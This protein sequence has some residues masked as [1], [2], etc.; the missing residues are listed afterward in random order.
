MSKPAILHICLSQGWGGLEMYP[1]RTSE[2]LADRGYTVFGLCIAGTPVAESMR[3]AGVEVFEVLSKNSLI[4]SQLFELNRWLVQRNVSIVHC[5]KSGDILISALLNLLLRRKTLFTEHMGVK[6]PKKD[7]YHRL[8]YAHIDQVLAISD[9][10]YERNIKSLPVPEGKI[11]R[12]WL[13]T[14]IQLDPVEDPQKIKRIKDEIALP[15]QSIVVGNIGRICSGKG[16]MELLETFNLLTEQYP[17]LHLL[18]VGGLEVSEGADVNFVQKLKS[19]IH[20]LR[21]N[22]RVHLIGFRKDTCQMLSIMDIVC[23]PNHN[24]AFGLTAI[25]AMAAKKA[26][27][28]WK[29]G[30]LPEVLDSSALLC[31]PFDNLDMA[32]KI[33][34]YLRNPDLMYDKSNQAYNRAKKEFSMASHISK[35]EQ[36]YL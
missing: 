32:S 7:F 3:R 30:A 5:H 10:T 9:K 14:D 33:E 4:I 18:L 8:V 6:R 25:E 17:Q 11:S 13:G 35:L 16:Q 34:N 36:F 19:R 29:T 15:N 23:L 22:S 20:D 31:Q 27:V 1:I 2:E 12:L 21:L 28:A 24:E 26:I